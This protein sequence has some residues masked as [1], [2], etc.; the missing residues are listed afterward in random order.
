M[1]SWSALWS[2]SAP[3]GDVLSLVGASRTYDAGRP[4]EALM[5]TD[6]TVGDG[7]YLV[8]TGASG[9]GK[10]TLLNLIGLLDKP[11][12][13]SYRID[14]VDVM[15]LGEAARCAIR[16]Q[17][18]GFVFQAFHLLP[19]RSALENVELGMLYSGRSRRECET[20]ARAALERVGL[21]NRIDANPRS[22]SGGERQRV[23]IA[24][25]VACSPRVL[26]CDEPTGNLDNA[27]TRNILELL[28]ELHGDGLSVVLVTH[29]EMVAQRGDRRVVV[30][31]GHVVETS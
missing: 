27:N 4:V 15:A 1:R 13:G 7:D 26:L 3:E 22:L 28:D 20:K 18:F 6:L 29:D 16:G 5:P 25:A 23:A 21:A 14:G 12:G 2:S 31:D 9:S 10:S 8:V 19:T 30:T 11:S 17:L 24:R